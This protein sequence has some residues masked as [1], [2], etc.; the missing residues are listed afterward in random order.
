[1][2]RAVSL[3]NHQVVGLKQPL[4][5]CRGRLALVYL[6]P[7][8]HSCGSLRH[9]ICPPMFSQ[10]DTFYLVILNELVLIAH[11]FCPFA[12]CCFLTQKEAAFL[13]VAV[14]VV[15]CLVRVWWSC[16]W[17]FVPLYFGPFGTVSSLN[18]M[19]R[20]SPARSRKNISYR[21]TLLN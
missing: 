16:V 3:R 9:L 13:C 7:K 19:M 14:L 5:I 17:P 11:L 8:P 18:L 15:L 1:M 4:C 21:W 12:L 6:F 10:D 20:S 2:V